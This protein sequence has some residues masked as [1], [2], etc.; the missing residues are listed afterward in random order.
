MRDEKRISVREDS[1]TEAVSGTNRCMAVSEKLCT[2]ECLK[3]KFFVLGA[4]TWIV[5]A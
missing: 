3:T 4:K 5:R 2:R 1:P